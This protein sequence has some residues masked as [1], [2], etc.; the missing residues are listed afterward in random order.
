VELLNRQYADLGVN[1]IGLTKVDRSS[2]DANVR[3]FIADNDMTFSVLKENGR[4]SNY[5]D[6]EGVPMT[7]ILHEGEVI[8]ESAGAGWL[9]SNMLE[10]IVNSEIA[11]IR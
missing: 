11:T 1:V 2:S 10:G 8:W 5:F 3:Q 6:L 7:V 4:C 9:D